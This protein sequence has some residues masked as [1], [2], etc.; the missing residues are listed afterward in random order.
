[1]VPRG[2]RQ[3]RAL[4]I[5]LTAVALATA[6]AWLRGLAGAGGPQAPGECARCPGQRFTLVDMHD[7]TGRV[8]R[9][10]V[11]L[12]ATVSGAGVGGM[13]HEQLARGGVTNSV[14]RL[15]RPKLLKIGM[16]SRYVDST[17]TWAEM[18]TTCIWRQV[19]IHWGGAPSSYD[20]Q[21]A[22]CGLS[23]RRGHGPFHDGSADVKSDRQA[24]TL[25][26]AQVGSRMRIRSQA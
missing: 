1:M 15:F 2:R 6:V 4:L 7:P 8:P 18:L 17:I 24:S 22:G 14:A 11:F 25:H 13:R 3:V 21:C 16:C 19:C 12:V 5:A 10:I 20:F 9:P 26:I 23:A